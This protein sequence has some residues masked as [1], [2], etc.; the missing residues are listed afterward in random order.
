MLAW[1]LLV[2]KMAEAIAVLP[3]PSNAAMF[4]LHLVLWGALNYTKEKNLV[5]LGVAALSFG[6][7]WLA[8]EA[9]NYV[10]AM[11]PVLGVALLFIVA[12]GKV[13][14]GASIVTTIYQRFAQH[15]TLANG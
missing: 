9:A 11:S 2:T 15:S 12:W 8:A 4:M 3:D 7:Y 14:F 1:G 6:T 5:M 10:A 13:I